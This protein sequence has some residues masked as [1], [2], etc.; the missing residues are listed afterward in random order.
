GADSKP[1]RWL[2]ALSVAG[3]YPM[4][5]AIKNGQPSV[6][7]ALAVLAV[8]RADKAARYWAAGAWLAV[9]TIKPQLVP[10]VVIYL[11]ARR[12]WRSLAAGA[13]CTAAAV[14]ITAAALGPSIW[15]EYARHVR[16]LDPFSG[17]RTPQYIV[18]LPRPLPPLI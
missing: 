13:A 3:F 7:L 4:F 12:S 11:A 18:N 8:Y 17:T 2:L 10:M 9:L 5:G 1:Q 16:S 14:A 6:L 15:I